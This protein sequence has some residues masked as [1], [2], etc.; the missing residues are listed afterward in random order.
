[1][2][3]WF[4]RRRAEAASGAEEPVEKPVSAREGEAPAEP[5]PAPDPNAPLSAERLDRALDRLRRENPPTP[6][7]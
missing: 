6:E 4:R 3:P 1:M 2:S 5:E 7:S